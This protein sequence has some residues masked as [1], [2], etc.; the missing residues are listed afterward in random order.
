[1]SLMNQIYIQR[2]K[3]NTHRV[4]LVDKLI[5]LYKLWLALQ[6]QIISIVQNARFNT[7]GFGGEYRE[8]KIIRIRIINICEQ[9]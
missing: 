3:A 2:S 9:T 8:H 1:M 7:N 5:Y 6:T 4:K